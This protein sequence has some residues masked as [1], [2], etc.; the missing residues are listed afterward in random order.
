MSNA[1]LIIDYVLRYFLRRL[2]TFENKCIFTKFYAVICQ[3]TLKIILPFNM[4]SFL[5]SLCSIHISNKK[6]HQP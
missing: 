5:W 1:D 2:R 4:L 6:L 3:S